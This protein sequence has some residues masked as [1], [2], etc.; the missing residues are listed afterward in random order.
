MT[1]RFRA[2]AVLID[3]DGTLVDSLPDI[4]CAANSMRAEL[5]LSPLAVKQIASYVGKGV[6]VLVHR[7]LT[8]TMND[9]APLDDF[10]RGRKVFN[11]C[12]SEVNGNESN[13]Y[14]G[15][16]EALEDLR[17]KAI[18]LACVTN[19]PRS[20]TMQLLERTNLKAAFSAIVS[21]D[22]TEERKPHAAPMLRACQLL[23]VAAADA[24]VIGDSENDALAARAAGCRVII[25]ETGYNEG[26]SF[27]DLDADAIVPT[28]LH[29]ARLIEPLLL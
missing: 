5:K 7:A 25:V 24:I 12:Y 29:A 19:K 8:E 22:D 1:S 2:R 16:R 6:D 15:V 9:Q 10:E 14:P 26:K 3:L 23:R 28:L 13:V 27:A 20:F 18:P 17:C 21:G 4:A 11:R